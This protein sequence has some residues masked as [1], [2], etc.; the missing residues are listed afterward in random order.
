MKHVP[1]SNSDV[2]NT[3]TNV[4]IVTNTPI[5]NA[6]PVNTTPQL[7]YP[8]QHPTVNTSVNNTLPLTVIKTNISIY[9]PPHI[10]QTSVNNPLFPTAQTVHTPSTTPL[11]TP[12][13]LYDLLTP[14]LLH[15]H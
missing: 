10:I 7:A 12:A 3:S 2:H 15:Q 4:T 8:P 5:P 1:Y 13:Y 11:N 9:Q 14:H 6:I